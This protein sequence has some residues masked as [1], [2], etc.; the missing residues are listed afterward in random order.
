[1]AAAAYTD[2]FV[3]LLLVHQ[4]LKNSQ[5]L[6]RYNQ[7][8]TINVTKLITAMNEDN[9][10]DLC[11]LLHEGYTVSFALAGCDIL[12]APQSFKHQ[13]IIEVCIQNQ[14]ILFAQDS[15]LHHLIHGCS[16]GAME[17]Y[18]R[19]V[20]AMFQKLHNNAV[21]GEMSDILK[22]L[23]LEEVV[24]DI[25]MKTIAITIAKGNTI[26]SLECIQLRAQNLSY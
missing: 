25:R 15:G 1:M 23:N 22:K 9:N 7:E 3:I 19:F 21:D 8:S 2:V 26:P 11:K 20:I 6:C 10:E 16:S 17:T 13:K 24:E 12:C 4:H 18:K 5:V 14:A